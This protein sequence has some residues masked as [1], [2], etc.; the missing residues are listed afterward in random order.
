M[1]KFMRILEVGD[2]HHFW[3]TYPEETSLL[4]T[5]TRPP[6]QNQ[7]D[8][9]FDCTPWNLA[10]ALR[11]ARRQRYDVVVTYAGTAGAWHPRY[12]LRAL[13][14]TPLRPYSALIR[15]FGTVK[16]AFADLPIPLVVLDMHDDSSIHKSN[17]NL[18]DRSKYYFKRELPVD[19]WLA[20][21]GSAHPNLP[22]TRIRRS[23]RWQLRV[24]KLRPISLQAGHIDIGDAET[25]F[26]AKTSDIFFAGSVELNSTVRQKGMEQLKQLAAR[27][28]KVDIPT[29]RLSTKEFYD[30]MSRAWIAW[31][32]SG[33]GWDCYRHYEAPQC[34]AVPLINYPTIFRYEPLKHGRHAIF[35]APER[36]GLVEAVQGALL[37]KSNLKAMALAGREHV[38][39][40]HVGRAFCEYVLK[41]A[42]KNS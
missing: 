23:K 1:E 26:S 29:E 22:T 39:L 3:D 20:F 37:D 2:H 41:S 9:F 4:W 30:R 13:A 36:D 10:K 42:L 18:L 28:V 31:S 16:L 14:R 40:H 33:R 32:P 21:Q 24:A 34:L 6:R 19:H 7:S 35:Y 17:F 12:W 5:G 27:G 25:V 11:D 38:Q 8:K 15:T